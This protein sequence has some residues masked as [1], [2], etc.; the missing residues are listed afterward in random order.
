MQMVIFVQ[1]NPSLILLCQWNYYNENMFEPSQNASLPNGVE[2]V[3]TYLHFLIY[4]V[5]VK[6]LVPNAHCNV[7]WNMRQYINHISNI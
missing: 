3:R 7:K 6:V 5:L 1:T 4:T 2:I